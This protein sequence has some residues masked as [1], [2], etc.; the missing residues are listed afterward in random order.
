M[1][2]FID[3]EAN[4]PTNE[5]ISIGCVNENGETFYELLKCSTPLDSYVKRVTHLT[6]K[7]IDKADD[8]ETVF[9]RFFDWVIRS[10]EGAHWNDL[11]FY[12]YGQ[13]DAAFVKATIGHIKDRRLYQLIATLAIRMIDYE[14]SVR[15]AFE[16]ADSIALIGAA[17]YF[18]KKPEEQTHNALDDAELLR[19]VY[20][21]IQDKTAINPKAFDISFNKLVRIK[22]GHK[23]GEYNS[24]EEAVDFCMG[25]AKGNITCDK[26]EKRVQNKLVSA[27]K[28]KTKY[29]GFNWRIEK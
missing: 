3:F 13:G 7:D 28:N 10:S 21:N 5:I 27:I 12:H 23:C 8:T 15:R 2:F 20:E 26:T 19:F 9:I 24:L 17:N 29:C 11:N 14:K 25:F 6:Q 16:S 4:S 22:N 18:K 1:N